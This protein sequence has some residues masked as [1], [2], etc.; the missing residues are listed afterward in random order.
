MSNK[1]KD[2]NVSSTFNYTSPKLETIQI[3]HEQQKD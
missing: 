3:V 2:E 1:V